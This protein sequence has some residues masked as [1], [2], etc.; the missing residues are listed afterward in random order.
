MVPTRKVSAYCKGGQCMKIPDF[1][2]CP[3][4]FKLYEGANGKKFGIKINDDVYM[5]KFPNRPKQNTDLS[6]ANGC[7]SE[8]LGSS[9]FNLI[10]IPAQETILGTYKENKNQKVVV[11]CKDFT[12]PNYELFSFAALKNSY[13][14]SSSNGYGVELEDILETI[15]AQTMISPDKL[16]ERFWDTFIVDAFIGNWD[17]HNGNWGILKN[18]DTEKISLA[19]V[20]DCGSCLYPQADA[21]TMKNILSNPQEMDARIF[22]R[23]LSAIKQNG[24]KIR[25]FDFISSLA[26]RD[27]NTALQRIVPRIDMAKIK[28]LI[29]S[30]SFVTPLQREFYITMLTARKERILDFSLKKYYQRKHKINPVAT[31]TI[32]R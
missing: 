30:I 6:Y 9:I 27:C 13:T 4:A 20:Y 5:L 11:A 24:Y 1:S 29:N 7:I 31:K 10:G 16:R 14:G 18:R 26:N 21:A 22:D 17:R 19:P 32:G 2:N 15:E 12:Y 3:T 25:Y 28:K 8:H 23:P